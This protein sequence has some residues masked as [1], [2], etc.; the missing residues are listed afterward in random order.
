MGNTCFH[1]DSSALDGAHPHLRGEHAGGPAYRPPPPG[2]SPP[3]WGTP[4]KDGFHGRFGGLIPTCVGN[5]AGW[6]LKYIKNRAHPHLRGE[7]VILVVMPRTIAGSSPPAWGTRFR[8]RAG[9]LAGGLIPT[10]VG[11]TSAG[12]LSAY[13]FGAHPHLRGEHVRGGLGRG[14]PMGSSPPAWGTLLGNHQLPAGHGLIPTCVGNTC[15]TLAP[16]QGRR[17]H[18]HLRGEHRLGPVHAAC[19]MGSSPPAWG[20]RNLLGPSWFR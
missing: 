9:W 14:R 19:V 3:A 10:C 13:Q 8:Y 16:D 2:S 18:P 17:A 12:R 15:F 4:V 20:T 7:H 11:N 1:G 5:T 6:G